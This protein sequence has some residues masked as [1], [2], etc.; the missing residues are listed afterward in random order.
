MTTPLSTIALLHGLCALV[1][2]LL[3]GLVLARPPLSRT[4]AWLVLA[5]AATVAW[6]AVFA[7]AMQ[8][9]PA[10][11][12]G[13]AAGRWDLAGWLEVARSA[14]WYGFILHLYR[15]RV[16]ARDQLRKAFVTMALLA[17]LVV[18]GTPLADTLSGQ[19]AGGI[20]SLRPAIDLGLAVCNVL[21]LENLY[22]NTP[23]ESR[24]N[25]NLLCVA[26]AVSSCTTWRCTPTRRCSAI[27]RSRC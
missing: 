25:I 4:G 19:P 3:A 11:Q 17:L 9:P 22:F 6:A 12:S 24:W 8:R 2:A 16:T 23:A 15:R 21:L 10:D 27:C 26:L 20:A 18:C 1:Y 13:W 14:A 5:C 7:L